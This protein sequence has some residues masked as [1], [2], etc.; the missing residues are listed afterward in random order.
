ML[1]LL[2]VV[3]KFIATIV[4]NSQSYP[5][6]IVK[7]NLNYLYY[8]FMI[9]LFIVVNLSAETSH[10][11]LLYFLPI[12]VAVDYCSLAFDG[13]IISNFVNLFIQL[14]LMASTIIEITLQIV[15]SLTLLLCFLKLNYFEHLSN[16]FSV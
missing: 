10:S 15:L 12:S 6:L 14:A 2:L 4:K 9:S 7:I 13:L 8:Y 11:F 3:L 1:F 5:K 16:S